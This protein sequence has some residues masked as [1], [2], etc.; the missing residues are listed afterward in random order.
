[1]RLGALA[2][3]GAQHA[4]A[5]T[6]FARAAAESRDEAEQRK[7]VWFALWNRLRQIELAGSGTDIDLVSLESQLAT[8]LQA[9]ID[10]W[11]DSNE[12]SDARLVLTGRLLRQGDP[13]GALRIAV[14]MPL[15]DPACD[16]LSPLIDLALD[17]LTAAPEDSAESNQTRSAGLMDAATELRRSLEAAPLDADDPQVLKQRIRRALQWTRVAGIDGRTPPDEISGL[18]QQLATE[19]DDRVPVELRIELRLARLVA[20]ARA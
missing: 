5:S 10:R 20:S 14:G 9:L 6:W 11:P 16:R 7:F 12:A 1:V 3:N 2:Q 19:A 18:L 13:L 17:R 8:D 4:Q 15:D